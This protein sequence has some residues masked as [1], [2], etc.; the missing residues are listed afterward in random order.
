MA[1]NKTDKYSFDQFVN[2]IQ[3]NFSFILIVAV[4]FTTGFLVGALWKEN[5]VLKGKNKVA[6]EEQDAQQPQGPDAE[7]L[8]KMPSINEDDYQRGAKDGKITIVEYSDYECPF[9]NKFHPTMLKV[10]EEYK[11]DVTWVYRHFPLDALHQD[12]RNL[13]EISECVGKYGGEDKFWE[14]TDLI[15]ERIVDDTKVVEEE[16]ALAIVAEIGV[17]KNKVVTCLENEETVEAVKEDEAGGKKAGISGTPGSI[18]LVKDGDPQL[19]PGALPY[20]AIKKT[21]EELL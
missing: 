4:V 5:Q 17:S 12:S 15:Y 2:F 11:N 1:E 10:M 20:E 16:N 7:K 3:N 19:I 13:A 18:I 9:C 8:G 6:L 14:F 21:I